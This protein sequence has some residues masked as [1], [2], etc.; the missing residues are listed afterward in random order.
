MPPSRVV[1]SIR[2]S[3]KYVIPYFD[4]QSTTRAYMPLYEPW[5]GDP[6]LDPGRPVILGYEA[7]LPQMFNLSVPNSPEI[8][9]IR[10]RVSADPG[11]LDFL[12]TN[13]ALPANP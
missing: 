11:Y 10:P 12:R 2:A 8:R 3:A 5:T 1:N 7:L 13:G 6:A 9:V 4:D